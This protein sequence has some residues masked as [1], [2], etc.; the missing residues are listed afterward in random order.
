[1]TL[2]TASKKTKAL[3]SVV[4]VDDHAS[5]R[6][7]LRIVL[8]IEGGYEVVGEAAGGLEAMSLCRA[9]QPQIVI[10]DLALPGL[11]GTHLLRLLM[12]ETW[13]V[14]VVIYSGAMD[15]NLMREAL[16]EEPHGFVRKEDSLPELRAALRAAATGGRHVS[17]WASRLMMPAKTDDALNKLNAPERAVLHMIGEGLQSKEIAK[18]LG[19]TMRTVEHHRQHLRDKLGL[20]DTTALV[21]FALQSRA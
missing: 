14:R 13:D 21:R 8:R 2:T 18:A 20:H 6:E 15:E 9:L 10:L 7:M 4:L 17:P 16:A 11:D 5:L 1:M 12:R 19:A 3:T